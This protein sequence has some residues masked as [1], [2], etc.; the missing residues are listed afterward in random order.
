MSKLPKGALAWALYDWANTGYAM[1]GLALIFPRLY[2]TYWGSGLSD[3]DQ[4]F[5]FTLTVG[6]A[7]FC[8]FVLAPILGS[9]AELGGIRKKLLLRFA[10]V[11]MVACAAMY[12]VDEGDYL[13]ATLVYI[14]G[15][16]CFYSANIFFDSMLERV[17]TAQNR[18]TISGLGFSFGYAAGFLLLLI[19]FLATTYYE[20]LGFGSKLDASR[21]LFVLAA[22]WW[23]IFTLPLVLRFHEE[24]RHNPHSL[25]RTARLGLVEAWVTLKAIIRQRNILWFLIAYQFYIDGV[26]TIIT[27]ASNYGSTI[28]FTEQQIITAFFCVQVAGV[29]CAVLFGLLGQ[30]IGP[31]KMIFV[32]ILVYLVVSFYGAFMDTAP[33]VIFGM[34]VSEIYILATL[35]GL[36]QGGIQALSRSYFTSIVPPEKTVAYFGFYSMIGKSAAILGPALMGLSALLF[37]NPE[38]PVL[39][40][41]IGMGMISV[42][43]FFGAG[44]L[45]VAGRRK[46]APP[47]APQA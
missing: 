9:I 6:V 13:S 3:S 44:F 1:I 33:T 10:T 18:H 2:K 38:H 11:G 19:T 17:S 35:I 5:W 7:S 21:F 29:P 32:A 28:G 8:V 43:F 24:P 30:K 37:N 47:A 22:A 40:T 31:R 16:V 34:E 45:A 14:V 26:N 42:L 4:T 41:R 20:P 46:Y 27:T 23:A 39:S 15:T 36:C 12:L 25:A